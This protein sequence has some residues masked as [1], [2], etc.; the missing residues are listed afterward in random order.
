MTLTECAN[1]ANLEYKFV[2]QRDRMCYCCQAR[3]GQII[4]TICYCP[5]KVEREAKK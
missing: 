3:G 5:G 2:E 4:Q 1:C